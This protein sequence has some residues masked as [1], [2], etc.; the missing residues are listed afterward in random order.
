MSTLVIGD[1]HG[2]LEATLAL[3]QDAGL[4]DADGAW[5]GDDT[6]L[7][8]MG[9]LVDN[10]PDGVPAIELVMR[11]QAEAARA[12]GAVNCLAGNH[13]VLLLA[14]RRFGDT[15]STGKG[16]TF[17]AEWKSSGG[18]D[19]DMARLTPEH[20]AWLESRPAMARVGETLLVHADA[21]F[22]LEYG[23]SI[24]EV[25]QTFADILHGADPALWNQLLADF[26]EH[27]AFLDDGDGRDRARAFLD[28]FG[29]SRIVHGHSPICSIT[30]EPA[31]N[32]RAPMV[33]AGGLCVDVDGGMY[34]GG[35]GFVF[36][37]ASP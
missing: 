13:D 30:G 36:A 32:V 9:D 2:Q 8:L 23:Q 4:S 35:P 3:L 28:R 22:Y 6:A 33:Y 19:H 37:L 15:S 25:N 16:G 7:W 29:G 20:V 11:L 10:G 14:A 1:I 5:T 17:L 12:G 24:A 34:L 26:G 21:L 27:H 18:E 31:E